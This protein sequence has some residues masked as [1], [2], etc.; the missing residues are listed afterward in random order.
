MK[1]VQLLKNGGMRYSNV[2]I[3]N[4]PTGNFSDMVVITKTPSKLKSLLDKKFINIDKA[5]AAI[6][7]A[8]FNNMLKYR[9]VDIEM[10]NYGIVPLAETD[11]CGKV[12]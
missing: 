7:V 6:D 12:I 2:R 10:M 5:V 3:E 1:K 9:R 4:N 8:G 11:A